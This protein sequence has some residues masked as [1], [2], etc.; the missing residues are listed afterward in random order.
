[1]IAQHRMSLDACACLPHKLVFSYRVEGIQSP[2]VKLDFKEFFVVSLHLKI[3]IWFR[4]A[5]SYRD[6]MMP[7]IA[8]F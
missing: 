6:M 3:N 5:G 7:Q 8:S 4:P 1:M 2:D